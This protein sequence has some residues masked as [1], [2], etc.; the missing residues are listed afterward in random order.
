MRMQPWMRWLNDFLFV[1]A[2]KILGGAGTF[3][4]NI[5]MMRFYRPEQY[6]VFALCV[7]AISLV[8]GILG[9][10][11]DLGVIRLVPVCRLEQAARG[12]AIQ[13]VALYF[14]ISVIVVLFLIGFPL[15]PAI[16]RSLFA[17]HGKTS[18]LF[19][20][21][22]AALGVLL[23]RSM[24]TFFQVENRFKAYGM[25]EILHI[26][27]KFSG[28]ALLLIAGITD[29]GFFLAIFALAPISIFAF[30]ICLS[31]RRFFDG[32]QFLSLTLLGELLHFVKWFVAANSISVAI[33]YLPAFALSQWADMREVGIYSAAQT[34][35]SVFPMLG[36][37][38]AI[39]LSPK[40]VRFCR[41]G[42]FYSL[43]RNFQRLML[44]SAGFMYIFLLIFFQFVARILLPN[45]YSDSIKVFML[46]LPS[47]LS[48]LVATPLIVNFV[49][50]VRPKFIFVL[51]SFS[52]PI[53]GLAYFLIVPEY[54][55]T[56]AAWV[57]LF[58]G[59]A[60]SMVLHI[61]S[62]KWA[63]RVSVDLES[64]LVAMQD[65]TLALPV[66]QRTPQA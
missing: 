16:Q 59:L 43:F 36:A 12:Q 35:S 37:Y 28:I 6:G 14:K 22:A 49:F 62:W 11:I 56:G 15:S 34:L 42:Q 25:L 40:I 48:W 66:S 8:D 50:F 44:A 60:R 52:L 27:A 47:A 63:R 53:L 24:Q 54:G 7:A 38:I 64:G 45:A 1:V 3:V 39:L 46:L 32:R 20:T 65:S 19:W 51:E 55:S 33:V 10:A 31:W 13:Q 61:A 57:T 41:Q 18:W 58:V 29:P 2:P 23:F 21:S 17:D 5:V 26:A 4:L 30:F 9:A